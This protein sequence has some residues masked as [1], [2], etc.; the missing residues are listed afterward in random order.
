MPAIVISACSKTYAH[1]STLKVA[2][3]TKACERSSERSGKW[4]GAGRKPTWATRNAEW[5]KSAAKN[6]LHR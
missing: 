6:P 3:R 2:R 5:A 4:N 1:K